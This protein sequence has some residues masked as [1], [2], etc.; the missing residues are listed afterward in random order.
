LRVYAKRYHS[1]R[2]FS[3]VIVSVDHNVQPFQ[4]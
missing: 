3:P 4:R 1:H 2:G